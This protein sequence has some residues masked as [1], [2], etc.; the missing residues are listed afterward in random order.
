M[1]FELQGL[2]LGALSALSTET[3]CA[4]L[5]GYHC[6]ALLGTSCSLCLKAK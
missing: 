1:I 6:E 3:T 4:E 2:T 5:Y